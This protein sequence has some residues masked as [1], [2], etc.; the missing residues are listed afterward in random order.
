MHL[1]DLLRERERERESAQERLI[2]YKCESGRNRLR[3]REREIGGGR[4]LSSSKERLLY[5]AAVVMHISLPIEL[6]SLY[7]RYLFMPCIFHNTVC[8]RWPLLLS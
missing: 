6:L 4:E 5:G 8:Y 3:E 1:L 7:R 2:L